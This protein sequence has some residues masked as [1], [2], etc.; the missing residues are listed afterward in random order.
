MFTPGA[1]HLFLLIQLSAL[2]FSG[3]TVWVDSSCKK[4]E[5]SLNG[6]L[7]DVRAMANRAAARTLDPSDTDTE[8]VFRTIFKQ[9]RSNAYY[10]ST[11]MG[12]SQSRLSCV[13]D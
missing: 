9:P 4:Y 5:S 3:P 11:M 6:A 8:N 12:V 10:S 2:A 1:L 13:P 7:L